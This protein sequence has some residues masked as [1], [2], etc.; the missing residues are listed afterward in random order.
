MAASANRPQPARV[1]AKNKEREGGGR[2]GGR[3][4]EREMVM[5]WS[6]CP[7]DVRVSVGIATAHP[8]ISAIED[9]RA[10]IRVRL[11][12][13]GARHRKECRLSAVGV[14]ADCAV[15]MHR[16]GQA[17]DSCRAGTTES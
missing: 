1:Q 10:E 8:V 7:W 12:W 3:E 14:S 16:P 4:G 17:Q 15:R 9:D 13:M 11:R 5:R 2:Q 6:A